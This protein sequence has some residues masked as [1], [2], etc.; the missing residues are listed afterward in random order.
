MLL[1]SDIPNWIA[2]GFIFAP[3]EFI[4]PDALPL[5]KMSLSTTYLFPVYRYAFTLFLLGSRLTVLVRNLSALLHPHYEHLFGN[6]KSPN[7]QLKVSCRSVRFFTHAL[8]CSFEKKRKPFLNA[9][10]THWRIWD[11]R[12]CFVGA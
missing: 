4:L 12:K 3:E 9:F 10:V 7:K 11:Q 2:F 1:A 6:H 5:C 8:R